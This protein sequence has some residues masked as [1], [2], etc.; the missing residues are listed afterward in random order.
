MLKAPHTTPCDL[1]SDQVDF[2][3]QFFALA[4]V[5]GE[6]FVCDLVEGAPEQRADVA[7]ALK[8]LPVLEQRIKGAS[9]ALLRAVNAP[10][11]VVSFPTQSLGGRSRG[12]AQNY[13]TWFM[14]LV[15]GERWE[16]RRHEFAGELAFVVTK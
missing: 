15:D 14:A 16:V 1:Y 7:L 3:N 13:A 5:Q 12:M 9:L 6:A 8:L 2:L 11:I 4:D 10:H